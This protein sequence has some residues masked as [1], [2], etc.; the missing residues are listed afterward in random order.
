M[1]AKT[2]NNT[3]SDS[4][5]KPPQISLCMIV[6]DEEKN[7]PRLLKSA[8]PW[9]DEIIVVD[10]GSSDNTMEIARQYGAK[11][12]E[13]PWTGSFSTHRNQSIAYANG[14]WIVILDADEELDRETA[15]QM[16]LAVEKLPANIGCVHFEMYNAIKDSQFSMVM[17]PRLFRNDG[18][19]KYEGK[20]HN[21]PRYS[22]GTAKS[23][24]KL[25]HYGYNL[26]PETMLQKFQ[27]RVDMIK[28]WVGK[29]PDNFVP[30][31]YLAQALLERSE[32]LEE[33]VTE[34]L[35]ALELANRRDRMSPTDYPRIYQPLVAALA[36]LERFEECEK[37]ALQCTKI[38]PALPDP[39]YYLSF[40]Y[41]RRQDLE[42]T[43]D[44]AKK[45]LEL[46]EEAQ[47]NPGKFR[48][49]ENL[50]LTEIHEVLWRLAV[51]VWEL[52]REDEIA[53]VLKKLSQHPKGEEKLKKG[54]RDNLLNGQ[55]ELIDIWIQVLQDVGVDWPWLDE[56]LHYIN[57]LKDRH[58]LEALTGEGLDALKA[59]NVLQAQ[60]YLGH[61]IR[62]APGNFKA[63]SGFGMTF[64]KSKE[65][66]KAKDWLSRALNANPMQLDT[67]ATL[68]EV[69]MDQDDYTGARLCLDKFLEINPQH[70]AAKSMQ[71]R[72][73]AKAP[74]S[75][76]QDLVR[77]N[78]P[79]FLI[80][81]VDDLELADVLEATPHFMMHKA[82]GKILYSNKA[83]AFR[84]GPWANLFTG[85]DAAPDQLFSD[86]DQALPVELKKFSHL[87]IWELIAE[88]QKI[89]LMSL[90]LISP[91][92][93]TN[94]WCV[95]GHSHGHMTSKLSQPDD[96]DVRLLVSG[97]RATRWIDQ[98]VR[99][100]QN[101]A[102]IT[103]RVREGFMYQL[104]RNMINS[105]YDLPAVDVLVVGTGLLNT[106]KEGFASQ[107]DRIFMGCQMVYTMFES[108]LSALSPRAYA[109]F[110][111]APAP[112]SQAGGRE[113]FYCLSWLRGENGQ[114]PVNGV[115]KE[116]LKHLDVPM[117]R[118]GSP[119]E[120]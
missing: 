31:A 72:Y 89:G 47:K 10:T 71:E 23:E 39:Y 69:L 94:G 100:S 83:P 95:D 49:M 9:V 20:V 1:G 42:R 75:Q 80:F 77:H 67:W 13:H 18:N 96:L 5:P 48:Y 44:T 116:V 45:F 8:A 63:L 50:T 22:G 111:Q 73:Q 58:D 28:K 14:D 103:R 29:E 15:P 87:T 106:M 33:C 91:A 60:A 52:R 74:Q 108:L 27:R 78:P 79:K 101:Q 81:L 92:Y 97:F 2:M 51:A 84:E 54:L 35:L 7:L 11:I 99:D 118:L 104:E 12:Y 64:V 115:V 86:E 76:P 17:H 62:K 61:V 88:R 112:D 34:S 56:Y 19:F 38:V 90:P 105:L 85:M 55:F 36:K 26:D 3:E 16:R 40:I 59:G 32:H 93:K 65:P 46:Q 53:D 43:Y 25:Y 102:V 70:P 24:I 82:W 110:G 107:P 113:G 57:E 41:I 114:A 109:V 119:R 6:K 117:D 120:A 4:S 37:Y 98:S 66:E 21:V 30:R 68:T